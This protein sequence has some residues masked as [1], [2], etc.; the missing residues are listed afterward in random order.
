MR[1]WDGKYPEERSDEGSG[2]YERRGYE[3]CRR[4][5]LRSAKSKVKANM[6]LTKVIVLSFAAL[7]TMV[8]PLEVVPSFVTL[9]GDASRRT[10][11]A[12]AFVASIA[13]IIVLTT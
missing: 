1:T 12:V 10:R 2:A 7:I 6:P 11:A 4:Q 13:C 8:N 3:A 9:T 5:I